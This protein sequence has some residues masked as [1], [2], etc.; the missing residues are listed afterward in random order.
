[1]NDI[2]YDDQGR[3]EPPVH[4]NEVETLVGFLDH[5]R[6]TLRWKADGLDDAAMRSTV[7]TSTMTIGGL[8]KHMAYVED[9]WFSRFLHDKAPASPWD[10]VDWDVDPD[11]EW[12]SAADDTAA[13]LRMLWVAAVERSAA[14]LD[15]ALVTGG[16]GQVARRRRP[17]GSSPSLRW[18]LVHMIEEYARHNGHV[19]LIRESLDGLVGE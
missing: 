6:A 14:S 12:H 19:D 8:V 16:L 13:S 1:M 18:I 5:Q 4:G 3:P 9:L 17:D 15:A 7:G 2:E 11:W 10:T